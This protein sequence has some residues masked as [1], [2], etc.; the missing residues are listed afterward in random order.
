VR[1]DGCDGSGTS[2][3][4]SGT[5]SSTGTGQF[6]AVPVAAGQAA[7][8]GDLARSAALF[9][10]ASLADPDAPFLRARAFSGLLLAGQPDRANAVAATG[11][12][13]G[14]ETITGLVILSRATAALAEGRARDAAADLARPRRSDRTRWLRPSFARGHSPRQATGRRPLR[15]RGGDRQA[16]GGIQRA[17]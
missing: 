12:V 10:Q 8:E 17:G 7:S 16:G 4:D 1:V 5:A 11:P 3:P 9:D 14:D 15:R 6:W 2:D 13:E